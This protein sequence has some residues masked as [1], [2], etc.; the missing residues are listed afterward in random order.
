[1]RWRCESLPSINAIAQT[2]RLED[3]ASLPSDADIQPKWEAFLAALNRPAAQKRI[4]AL[5]ELGFH[6]SGDVENRLGFYV[7]QI[8]R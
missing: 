3:V 7:G 2:K 1:M 6:R 8:G 4:S 5:M